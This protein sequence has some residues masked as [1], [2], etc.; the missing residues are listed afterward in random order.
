MVLGAYA[1]RS[2]AVLSILILLG[3][4]SGESLP[5]ESLDAGI[6]LDTP[7]IAPELPM[8]IRRW[9]SFSVTNAS[10]NEA[11]LTYIRLNS[12]T[13]CPPRGAVPVNQGCCRRLF[14]SQHPDR[15]RLWLR[16]SQLCRPR[17]FQ[18]FC[19]RSTAFSSIDAKLSF[20]EQDL[21]VPVN[22]IPLTVVRTYNSFNALSPRPSDGRGA[23]GEGDFGPGWTG[24][25]RERRPK[26]HGRGSLR[27]TMVPAPGWLEISMV[28]PWASTMALEMAKPRPLWPSARARDLSAR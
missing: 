11:K 6:E 25:R 13:P 27:I 10:E 7:T 20:S 12:Q 15:L 1:C 17:L 3:R 18:K 14:H 19:R 24:S 4:R 23:G 16:L 8:R 22:G 9:D 2:E 21:V 26:A 5:G 28:P